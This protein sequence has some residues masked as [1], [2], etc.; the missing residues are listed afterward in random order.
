MMKINFLL[1]ILVGTLWNIK[2]FV[3]KCEFTH[4]FNSNLENY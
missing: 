1:L 4:N 2:P 3:G